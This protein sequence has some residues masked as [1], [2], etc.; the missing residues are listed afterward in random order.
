MPAHDVT[1]KGTFGVNTYKLTYVIDGEE[2]RSYDVA[3]GTAITPEAAPT[4]EGYTFSGWSEIPGTMPANDVTVNGTFTANTYFV[5]FNANGGTGSMDKQSF[6]YDAAQR[7]TAN[8]FTKDGFVFAGW[9]TASDGTGT[10]YDDK[11][12]VINLTTGKVDVVLYAQWKK[13]ANGNGI[14]DENE[15]PRTVT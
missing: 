12:E 10:A 2:Y 3:Y 5:E 9:N 8:A 11:A 13:D 15:T 4:K 14:P 1:V 7:L 6:V